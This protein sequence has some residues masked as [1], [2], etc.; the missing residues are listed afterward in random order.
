MYLSST[1]AWSNLSNPEG[2]I[3]QAFKALVPI[4]IEKNK[5]IYT[6]II[7]HISFLY[8]RGSPQKNKKKIY[9]GNI[10]PRDWS[11]TTL[12]DECTRCSLFYSRY[13]PLLRLKFEQDLQF[14]SLLF[15]FAE[16]ISERFDS[17][18]K[19]VIN[20]NQSVS[21]KNKM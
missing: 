18:Y 13:L 8:E 7:K 17:R 5:H 14:R 3:N 15:A 4:K 10:C 19:S 6:I 9:L 20:C 12:I 16:I 2:H 21:T 11:W 1:T